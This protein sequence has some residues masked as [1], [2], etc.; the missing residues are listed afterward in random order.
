VNCRYK[1]GLIKQ[2]ANKSLF[3]RSIPSA[4][5]TVREYHLYGAV[6]IGQKQ[7]LK[8]QPEI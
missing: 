7:T 1:K 2:T 6:F 3:Y 8:I 5:G 4:D